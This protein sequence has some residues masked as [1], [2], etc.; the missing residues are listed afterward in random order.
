MGFEPGAAGWKVKT[1]PR[2]YGGHPGGTTEMEVE[3]QSV[4]RLED[5]CGVSCKQAR[6]DLHTHIS[7]TNICSSCWAK[8]EMLK[9]EK[10]VFNSF[11]EE[12][13]GK[14]IRCYAAK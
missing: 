3:C 5:V 2:S 13:N 11:E 14:E 1:K 6:L 7:K 4:L 10:E 12:H 8:N 9:W